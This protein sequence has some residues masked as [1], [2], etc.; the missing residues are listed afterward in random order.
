MSRVLDV[1]AGNS[2]SAV[3]CYIS[4]VCRELIVGFYSI[5]IV[6]FVRDLGSDLDKGPGFLGLQFALLSQRRVH[7]KFHSSKQT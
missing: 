3:Q 2:R 6:F 7:L 1:C 5:K 4:P